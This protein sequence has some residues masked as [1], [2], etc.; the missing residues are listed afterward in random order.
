MDLVPFDELQYMTQQRRPRKNKETN[1]GHF[2]YVTCELWL[3]RGCNCYEKAPMPADILVLSSR[4][5]LFHAKNF[6]SGDRKWPSTAFFC[7]PSVAGCPA[8]RTALHTSARL[9][10]LACSFRQTMM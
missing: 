3:I 8:G 6:C 9:R 4:I 2:D 7:S 10:R 1:G 5:C